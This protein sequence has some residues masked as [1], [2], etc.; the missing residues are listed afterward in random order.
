MF[1]N[2]YLD[3]IF[4]KELDRWESKKA[5]V[6]LQLWVSFDNDR[7]CRCTIMQYPDPITVTYHSTA[8]SIIT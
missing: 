5:A 8:I 2:G 3:L 1:E 6:F 7:N 4:A